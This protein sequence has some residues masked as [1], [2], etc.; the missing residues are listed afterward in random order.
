MIRFM[1]EAQV[2]LTNCESITDCQKEHNVNIPVN[3][4][5]Q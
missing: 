5:Y 2:K 3:K 4:K 1:S